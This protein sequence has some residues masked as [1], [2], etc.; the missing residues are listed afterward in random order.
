MAGMDFSVAN[1]SATPVS[2]NAGNGSTN[3]MQ[4]QGGQSGQPTASKDR[5][6]L[7]RK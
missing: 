5:P 6:Q 7:N 3:Q 2:D 1:K 4:M